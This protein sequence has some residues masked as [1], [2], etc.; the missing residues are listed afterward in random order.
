[1]KKRRLTVIIIIERERERDGWVLEIRLF[2]F[3]CVW[4]RINISWERHRETQRE[5]W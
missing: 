1:M 5:E 2:C 4:W 3:V